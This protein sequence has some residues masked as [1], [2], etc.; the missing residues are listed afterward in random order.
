MSWRTAI[1]LDIVGVLTDDGSGYL[2]VLPAEIQFLYTI[3]IPPGISGRYPWSRSV[4]HC[5]SRL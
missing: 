3:H 1:Y 4:L 5:H 2:F